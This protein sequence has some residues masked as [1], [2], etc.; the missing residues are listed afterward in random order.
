MPLPNH[1]FVSSCDGN[2]YDTRVER[3]SEKPPLRA[4]YNR[5]HNRIETVAD[6]KAA[7]R[8]GKFTDLGGYPLYFITSDC[9]TMSFESVLENLASV[10]DSVATKSRDGWR[11]IAVEINYEDN[12]MVCCHSGKRIPS[13]YGDDNEES[14]DVE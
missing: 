8:H 9:D 7:L 12:D 13:A 2:L 10:M 14:Q 11:V 6:L 3:W 1:L 4:N 5:G